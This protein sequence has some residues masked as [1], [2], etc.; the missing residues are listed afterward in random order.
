MTIIARLP[1]AA[2]ALAATI[3]LAGAQPARD[4]AQARPPAM[5]PGPAPGWRARAAKPGGLEMGHAGAPRGQ[6]AM[7]ERRHVAHDGYDGN[8]ARPDDADGS[9]GWPACSR[10]GTS[11]VRSRSTRRS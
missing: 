3:S 9:W 11:T 1:L 7:M 10:F 4:A 2:A 8:D 6:H 5:P